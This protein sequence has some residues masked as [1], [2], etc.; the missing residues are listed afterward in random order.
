MVLFALFDIRATLTSV[1]LF[2]QYR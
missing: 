1:G 2:I